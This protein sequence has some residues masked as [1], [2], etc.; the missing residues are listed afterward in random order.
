MACS[1]DP[2]TGSTPPV[3]GLTATITPQ[4]AS[5]ITCTYTNNHLTTAT[6]TFTP[7]AGTFPAAQSVTLASTTPGAA[8]RYTTD[9]STPTSTTGTLYTG[10]IAVNATTTIKAIA[11]SAGY[12]D[13]AVATATYTINIPVITSLSPSSGQ[14]GQT[15]TNVQITGQ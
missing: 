4:Q 8:I 2:A 15:L 11:Y 6:P 1:Q 7:A 10:A 5:V 9:G 3:S 14:Q 12:F 13:S